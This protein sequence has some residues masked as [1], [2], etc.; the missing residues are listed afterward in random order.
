M[1][2]R[3]RMIFYHTFFMLVISSIHAKILLWD[4]SP[5]PSSLAVL[6]QKIESS[7]YLNLLRKDF[8]NQSLSSEDLVNRAE[9]NFPEDMKEVQKSMA[10]AIY[11][12]YLSLDAA[13]SWRTDTLQMAPSPRFQLFDSLHKGALFSRHEAGAG[14]WNSF[15][16]KVEQ[17]KYLGDQIDLSSSH[18]SHPLSRLPT[19][20]RANKKD[21]ERFILGGLNLKEAR[22]VAELYEFILMKDFPLEHLNTKLLGLA[23]SVD[24]GGKNPGEIF[25][26]LEAEKRS[27]ESISNLLKPHLSSSREMRRVRIRGHLEEE[28]AEIFTGEVKILLENPSSLESL[29]PLEQLGRLRMKR[30]GPEYEALSIDLMQGNDTVLQI[31]SLSNFVFL[32]K[33]ENPLVF[34]MASKKFDQDYALARKDKEAQNLAYLRKLFFQFPS[35]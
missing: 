29:I 1:K 11:Q 2:S 16:K 24:T 34:L 12:K 28:I 35:K 6:C 25:F 18:P 3:R 19:S 13:H 17:T 27:K 15:R 20:L 23:S 30:G 21:L 8:K 14:A 22:F 26:S 4:E 33:I 9:K 7:I 5:Y 10:L 32:W 31:F